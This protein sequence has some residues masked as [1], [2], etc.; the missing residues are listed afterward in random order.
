MNTTYTGAY[1]FGFAM[2]F[3][4]SDYGLIL[5]YHNIS[6]DVRTK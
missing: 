1:Y 4:K 3:E 2:R 5:T 6:V